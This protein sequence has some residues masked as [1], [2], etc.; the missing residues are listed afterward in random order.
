MCAF[1][2]LHQSQVWYKIMLW[3][4]LRS[5]HLY[6]SMYPFC[7]VCMVRCAVQC[8]TIYYIVCIVRECCFVYKTVNV[9]IESRH[10]SVK[11]VVK[12][13]SS[14]L[15][16]EFCLVRCWL[17]EAVTSSLNWEKHFRYNVFAFRVA[18]SLSHFPHSHKF[19]LSFYVIVSL[20]DT[21]IFQVCVS[22]ARCTSYQKC[23][24]DKCEWKAEMSK[25]NLSLYFVNKNKIEYNEHAKSVKCYQN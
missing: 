25:W 6:E 14:S 22:H 10:R 16:Y 7:H 19:F 4:Q 15:A 3:I 8:C 9:H 12:T 11:C 1:I 24:D 5:I 17:V 23:G 21:V 18:C 2:L 20:V 13:T